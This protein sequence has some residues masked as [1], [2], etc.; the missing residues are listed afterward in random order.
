MKKLLI[1]LIIFQLY[2]ISGCISLQPNLKSV[3]DPLTRFEFKFF[4]VLPPVGDNWYYQNDN[5]A[6]IFMKNIDSRVHTLVISIYAKRHTD[7]FEN[8]EA[9]LKFIEKKRGTNTHP[10]RFEDLIKDFK[11]SKKF[12][13]YC[14]EYHV[15][16]KDF[17]PARKDGADYL[18]IDDNGYVF[19]HPDN[20]TIYY[21]VVS[22]ERY[23]PGESD[24]NVAQIRKTFIEGIQLYNK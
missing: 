12:G 15:Q 18:I 1:S 2:I 21:E 24:L 14:V 5:A 4:S 13:K 22:S 17:F 19:L 8:P 11:L 16:A 7:Y 10:Q 3:N 23:K 9:L 6:I 20:G